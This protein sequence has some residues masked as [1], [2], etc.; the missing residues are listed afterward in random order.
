MNQ[1]DKKTAS[2]DFIS[3]KVIKLAK[4]FH[5]TPE[6]T[7]DAI[8][9]SA[10]WLELSEYEIIDVCREAAFTLRKTRITIADVLG[11]IAQTKRKPVYNEKTGET[12]YKFL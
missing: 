12:A 11:D 1:E 6:E 2:K 10:L 5:E 4:T 7:F 3:D 9:Q 8:I